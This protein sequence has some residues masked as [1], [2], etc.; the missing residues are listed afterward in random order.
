MKFGMLVGRMC[1]LFS[2]RWLGWS[3]V[4]FGGETN[5]HGFVNGEILDWEVIGEE[6]EVR[7]V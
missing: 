1:H 4:C 6:M 3:D 5:V 7:I 2:G